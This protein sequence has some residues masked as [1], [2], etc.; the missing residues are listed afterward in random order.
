MGNDGVTAHRRGDRRHEWHPRLLSEE[1]VRRSPRVGARASSGAPV[2]GTRPSRKEASIRILPR[3]RRRSRDEILPRDAAEVGT[4][5]VRAA[6]GEACMT[7]CILLRRGVRRRVSGSRAGASEECAHDAESPAFLS[8]PRVSKKFSQM[9]NEFGGGARVCI[10]SQ[11][12]A[13]SVPEKKSLTLNETKSSRSLRESSLRGG[14][15]I[16]R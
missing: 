11:L 4:R 6:R 3:S 15:Q 2:F 10:C 12:R 5:T 7:P 8:H 13:L 16:S 14:T 9:D 1:P